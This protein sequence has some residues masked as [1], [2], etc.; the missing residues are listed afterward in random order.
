MRDQIICAALG[1]LLIA[2]GIPLARRKVRPNPLYGLRIPATFADEHVWYEANAL[3]GRD[4]IVLG[5]VLVGTGL[6]L[7]V[8][9]RF[10][11]VGPMAVCAA[12]LLGGSIVGLIRGWRFANRLR[13]SR[14]G[15]SA[16]ADSRRH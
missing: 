4:L 10:V 7:P 1:A 12:I 2:L 13:R 6:L 9:V 16:A 3:A 11:G 14:K 15:P 8:L 5:A